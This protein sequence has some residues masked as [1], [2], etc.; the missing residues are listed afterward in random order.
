MASTAE[1]YFSQF[2]RL[3]IKIK[4]KIKVLAN[5]VFGEGSL[6]G[7]QMADLWQRWRALEPL[8]FLEVHWPYGLGPHPYDFI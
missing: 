2:W 3:E 4:S 6:L 8:L 1:T 7:L 5:L